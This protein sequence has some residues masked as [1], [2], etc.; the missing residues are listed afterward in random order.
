MDTE[1]GYVPNDHPSAMLA[2]TLRQIIFSRKVKTRSVKKRT[3]ARGIK[4][5]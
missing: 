5:E 1:L 3:L 2:A 4:F